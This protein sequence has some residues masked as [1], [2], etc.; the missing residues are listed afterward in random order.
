MEDQNQ[1]P[2]SSEETTTA[3]T[4][5]EVTSTEPSTPSEAPA[6]ATNPGS[7]TTEPAA[8][9]PASA[10]APAPAPAL[11]PAI[12]PKVVAPAPV[13]KPVA[14]VQ[15]KPAAAAPVEDFP[16]VTGFP[17]VDR[18]L[19]NVP[20]TNQTGILRIMDYIAAMHPKRPMDEK[21]GA[22]AQ[23]MLY[24]VLQN[25]INRE[26]EHFRAIF[27]AILMLFE[28]EPTGVF[29]EVNLFR[30]MDQVELTQ[31]DRKA[32]ER[33][34]NLIKVMGPKEG[35]AQAVKQVSFDNSLRFGL[36]EQGRQRVL[37]F[38]NVGA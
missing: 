8:E 11:A 13:K 14:V 9:A 20:A 37:D 21:S 29:K 12:A 33:I 17:E 16:K 23:A 5:P 31:S 6:D 30:F 38:F 2:T 34:L 3:T 28:V 32:F 24:K 4:S 27:S 1:Q 35:R 25:T 22:R 19:K 15:P 26:D 36:T 7:A 10:P 18:L